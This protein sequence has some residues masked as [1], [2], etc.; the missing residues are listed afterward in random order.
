MIRVKRSSSRSQQRLFRGELLSFTR[1]N[2]KKERF[3]SGF[4]SLQ[5][6]DMEV[7]GTGVKKRLS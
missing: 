6:S 4:V 1:K 2:A 5:S 3:S 7:K